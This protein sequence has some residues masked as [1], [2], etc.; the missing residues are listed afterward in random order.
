MI[1]GETTHDRYI[2]LGAAVG[3][4][5]VAL[6]ARLPVTFGVLTTETLAQAEDR[7]GGAHGNKGEDAALAAVEL[8]NTLRGIAGGPPA[9]GRAG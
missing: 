5:R 4:G 1:R 8:V 9:R 7:S 3:L 2:A 6:D